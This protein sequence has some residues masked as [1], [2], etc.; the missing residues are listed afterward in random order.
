VSKG[1]A[2]AYPQKDRHV[3]G[4]SGSG[5]RIMPICCR[6]FLLQ[7]KRAAPRGAA[8]GFA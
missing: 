6:P 1:V 5:S 3:G 7:A 8:L 4:V 2:M